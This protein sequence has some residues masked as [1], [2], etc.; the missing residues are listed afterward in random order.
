[1]NVNTKY[2]NNNTALIHASNN[3]HHKISR[4]I[5]FILKISVSQKCYNADIV[6]IDA[7]CNSQVHY[8]EPGVDNNELHK[9]V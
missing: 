5:P 2:Y 3:D 6:L 4:H 8:S 9:N 1:M 7:S